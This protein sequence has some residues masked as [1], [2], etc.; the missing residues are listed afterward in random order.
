MGESS[1]DSRTPGRRRFLKLLEAAGVASLAGCLGGD[2]GTADSSPTGTHEST[3]STTGTREPTLPTT[4]TAATTAEPTETEPSVQALP[5]Q[6]EAVDGFETGD[7][8]NFAPLYIGDESDWIRPQATTVTDNPITGDHS[9]QWTTNG[10][11]GE[12]ALLSNAFQLNPPL[13]A[14]VSVRIDNRN[15]EG[16]VGIAIAESPDNAAVLRTA[17]PE[18]ELATDAW[19]GDAVDT[20]EAGLP[21]G[22]PRELS[23]ELDGETV[24]GTLSK[25][26]GTEV[27]S[28]SAEAD[29]EPNAIAL[30]VD[31]AAGAETSI[32][33]DD[34]TVTGQPYRIRNDEWTR[35]H[36][37][38]VLPRKPDLGEDQGNWV[39]GQD[40]FREDGTYEM[41][42]RIRSNQG[43]G[44]GYGY[45]Q[46]ENGYD[47]EKAVDDN[48]VHVPDYGQSSMEGITVL[49]IDGTYR[50]WYCMNV[51]NTWEIAYMTSPD[52]IDWT[53]K[54]IVIEG[55]AKDPMTTYVDGTYYLAAI[56]PSGSEFSIYT[57]T[58]G[59]DWT[60]E[61]TI[62]LRSGYHSHPELYYVRETE[63]FWLYAFAEGGLNEDR[64]AEV[65]RASS[66]SGTDFE[67]LTKTWSDPPLGIDHRRTGGIDYG[68][69]LTD[70]HGQF[71]HDRRLPVYYQSRHNYQNN[72]PGW[73]YGGDGL[74]TLAGRFSGLF[75][76]IPTTVDG[77]EYDYHEFPLEAPTAGG[78]DVETTDPATVTVER[79]SPGA[80][81]AAT[82][83]LRAD[84][85][86]TLTLSASGLAGDTEY[87]LGVGDT[88]ATSTTDADGAATFEATV[89]G[90]TAT[91]F[92]LSEK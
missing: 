30:Y 66:E 65:R 39:G 55:Y 88:S 6:F 9:L 36:P 61:T 15:S 58:D 43:R 49:K 54:G 31:T 64:P 28:L 89:S 21:L 18:I 19:D 60:R 91:T 56:A 37:F 78:F 20:A 57:S 14:S 47:W 69:F 46:S 86:S 24:T 13:E 59:M 11:P 40:V 8:R 3:P 74:V 51:N 76:G 1:R 10:D 82:G 83:V 72:R 29:L 12:W 73:G 70:S 22:S 81:T 53:D 63:T 4:G 41:W 77:Q 80:A 44:Q 27:A 50:A 17:F 34:V 7:Y 38:V 67:E 85:S 23:I 90:D 42:Y 71:E 2:D 16:S 92:E 25:L 84:A 79:W 48:P 62:D 52:G 87:V 68:S 75:E 26:D 45:A 32:T 35:A 33:F 5:Q